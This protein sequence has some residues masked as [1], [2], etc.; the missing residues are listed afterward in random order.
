MSLRWYT[1]QLQSLSPDS[2]RTLTWQLHRALRRGSPPSRR[3]W[4]SLIERSMGF[5]RH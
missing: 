3:E 2:R 5:P 1:A 4:Q